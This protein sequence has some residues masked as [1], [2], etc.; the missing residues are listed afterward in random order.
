MTG[1]LMRGVVKKGDLCEIIGYGKT[2]KST[3][4][5]VEMFRQLLERA[6]AGD[7]VGALIRGLKRDEVR[8]GM[9]LCKPGG[10][11]ILEKFH[12]CLNDSA[13]S[14]TMKQH[15]NMEAQVELGSKKFKTSS[16][17]CQENISKIFF[18]WFFTMEEKIADTAPLR[19]VAEPWLFRRR[20]AWF[21]S[22]EAA[23][24]APIL[25]F[26]NFLK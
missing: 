23:V 25:R 8:R 19:D 24:K 21:K 2:L 14:G 11:D 10:I 4:T 6:E 20:I 1:M 12:V 15:D 9:G 3:V 13:F 16:L 22:F 7:Q 5:G 17:L 26:E 18:G